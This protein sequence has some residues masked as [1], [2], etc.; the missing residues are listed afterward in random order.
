MEDSVIRL[1]LDGRM[2]AAALDDTYSEG[3]AA[4]MVRNQET[5]WQDISVWPGPW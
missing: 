4:L 2:V 5:T 1:W 3:G